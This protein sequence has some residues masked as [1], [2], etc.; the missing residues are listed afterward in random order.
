MATSS[1]CP[2]HLLGAR[3]VLREQVVLPPTLAWGSVPLTTSILEPLSQ[4]TRWPWGTGHP[5]R[6][7]KFLSPAGDGPPFVRRHY[8]AAS[9]RHSS[10]RLLLS[11]R[12]WRQP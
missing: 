2:R 12:G 10:P 6:G 3:P 9:H 11:P 1:V 4:G 8:P 5:P 7:Q